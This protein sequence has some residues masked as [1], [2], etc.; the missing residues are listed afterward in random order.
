MAPSATTANPHFGTVQSFLDALEAQQDYAAAGAFLA[1][2]FKMT[3]PKFSFSTKQEWMDK[4]P[5]VHKDGPVFGD[6]EVNAA[7]KI[8]R[9]GK[10]KVALINLSLYESYHLTD[11]GMIESITVA[12]N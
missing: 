7:G 1:D 2:D 9:K 3:T 10:K 4:F 8:G 11:D 5:S 12:R 6:L